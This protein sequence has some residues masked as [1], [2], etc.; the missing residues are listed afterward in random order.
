MI[1]HWWNVKEATKA[2]RFHCLMYRKTTALIGQI[3]TW[4]WT[5]SPWITWP[6]RLACATIPWSYND[7]KIEFR[8]HKLKVKRLTVPCHQWKK[9]THYVYRSLMIANE[10][11]NH[12]YDTPL[13]TWE[14]HYMGNAHLLKN[15][16]HTN[17]NISK[18]VLN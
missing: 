2:L 9:Q 11:G 4:M 5:K 1:E 7:K 6:L 10:N 12:Q 17:W 14:N 3:W 18:Y 15:C 16:Q 13:S 8:V